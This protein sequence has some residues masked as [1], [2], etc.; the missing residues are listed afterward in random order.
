MGKIR[1]VN[2][3][4]QQGSTASRPQPGSEVWCAIDIARTKLVYCVRWG[5]AEQH[6][7]STPLGVEHVR[8]LVERYHDC[9]LHVAYEACGFGYEIA[10]W[11][12]AQPGVTVTVVAPSRVERPPGRAVKTD[13]VDAGKLASKL[14]RGDLKGIYIP[15]RTLHQDRSLGRAYAQCLKE[16]KRAQIRIRSLLQEHGHLGPLPRQGWSIYAQWLT[17]CA[18]PPAVRTCVDG[19]LQLR[20]TADLQARRLHAALGELAVSESYKELVCKLR[21]Q[22]GIGMYSAIRLV[23]ELG[24]MN[25]FPTTDSLP[26][27]LGLTPSQYSSGERDHRGHILKSGPG[28]LRAMLLQCAWAT[29]RQGCDRQLCAVFE[30]LAPR[31][32]RKRAIIAVARRLAIKVRTLWLEAAPQREA[33]A[34]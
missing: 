30:S 29:V 13:R 24:T 1:L 17:Q 27:Y 33:T 19:H 5:G 9:R 3:I 11:L 23:L 26:H 10:W 32:G 28:F 31:I 2:G 16:R 34:A 7:L 25:R 14:E 12:Q 22:S 18:L 20:A 8:A 15:T 4:G 21:T 6:R